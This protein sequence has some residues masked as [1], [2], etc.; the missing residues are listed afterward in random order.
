MRR[1]CLVREEKS[2]KGIQQCHYQAQE[3]AACSSPGMVK[4]KK[5]T[6]LK[7]NEKVSVEAP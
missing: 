2:R 1:A 3:S 5:K 7:G 6:E 4:I